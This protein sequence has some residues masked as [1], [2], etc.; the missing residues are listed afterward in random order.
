[1]NKREKTRELLSHLIKSSQAPVQQLR[2]ALIKAGQSNLLKLLS[3]NDIQ[4]E[5]EDIA[6][7]YDGRC[8][9]HLQGDTYIVAKEFKGNLYI[10]IRNYDQTGTNKI[11]TKQG[12][13][14]NLSR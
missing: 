9:I 5:E 1:M 13:T 10:H 4:A 7:S 11:P 12:A 8:F 6:K 3:Q 14:L 2:I